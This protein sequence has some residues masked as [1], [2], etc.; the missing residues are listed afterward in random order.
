MVTG[1]RIKRVIQQDASTPLSIYGQDDLQ[2]IGA[3]D[4]R[5]IVQVLTIN[6]GSQN[7]SDNL[8]QNF[9][10]GTSN[11]SLRG[12]GVSSTLVLL[13][14]RRQVTS[15]V[16]TD[17]GASFV[18]TA[19]LAPNLA[20]KQ[21]E[22]LKDGASAIYGSDAV[23]GVVNFITRD[24][25]NGA[26]LQV[27]Q[28]SRT[29]NGSQDDTYVDFALGRDVGDDGHFLLA[30]SYLDRSSLALGEVDWLRPS[31]S[32]FGNP[33]SFV[34]PS[35]ADAENPDGLTVADPNCTANGGTLSAGTH[36]NT[37]CLFDFGPQVTAVS[38]ENRFQVF[39]RATWDWNDATRLWAEIGYARND[40][41]RETSP[42]FPVLN[43]PVVP[44]THP[45]NPYGEDVSFRGRPYGVGKPPEI[46]FYD[47]ETVRLAAGLEGQFTDEISWELS[48]VSAQNDA[49]LNP[50]DVIAANFQAA[51]RGFGGAECDR[52]DP[53]GAGVGNCL[54]FDPF[55]PAAANNEALRSFLIGDYIGEAESELE[56]IEAVVSGSDL[57]DMAGGPAAF[58]FGIQ[59][60]DESIG[61][62]YNALTQQ[63]SFAFLIG[64]QNFSGQQNVY[65]VFA[66]IL[67]PFSDN[68]EVTAAVRHE[69]YGGSVGSTTNPKLSLL[70]A[71]TQTLSFRGSAS[72]SFRA[73]SVNQLKGAHTNFANITDPNDGSTT[74]GGNRTVGNPNLKPETSTAFNVGA[75]LSLADWDF[76]VDYWDFSF[77]D[78]LTR[79]SVQG[80]VNANPNDSNRVIRT[81]AGTISIV[82]TFFINAEAIDTSGLDFSARASYD[83]AAGT[84]TPSLD[85]TWILTYDLT[86]STG[87]TTDGVGKLNRNTV[88][89]PTPELRGNLGLAWR[90]GRHS[91]NI[92]ARYVDSY[93][94]DVSG[95]AIKSFTS[96]DF[97]YRLDFGAFLRSNS[98]TSLTLGVINATDEDPPFVD[99]AG[100]YDP[101]T[102][103]PRGRRVY[104]KLGTKFDF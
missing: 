40:T 19:A 3:K 15:S 100:S 63:D 73:P 34:R 37:F 59:Y 18:D 81:A 85:A 102:G 70:W 103:D 8:T 36:G 90:R 45:G 51:L 75:S 14:G 52:D 99:V 2:D 77:E 47:H 88:G 56:V 97:Q 13:N 83:T 26:E 80:V 5:D 50:L 74:F 42:S 79:E 29:N 1:S 27:E 93:K 89:N 53:A 43:A 41:A 67:L 78:V 68:F 82:K 24:D 16:L 58:A 71:P 33:G 6:A 30:T 66:E 49:F 12:L 98:Q 35:L 20:I 86:D 25:L 44:A 55:D 72:T 94:N 48:W 23:A 61:A 91:A 22:I 31:Y 60:R 39:T 7:N 62:V 17:Q 46:N 69:D 32:S 38:K 87:N 10:G 28:R 64:N 54:Y 101:R 104:I 9:T 95:A 96:I 11:I 76:S 92:F 4:V 65:A 84:F 21:V 57:F